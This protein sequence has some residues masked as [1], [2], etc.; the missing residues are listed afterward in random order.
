MQIRVLN[1]GF[2]SIKRFIE[3]A[4][5]FIYPKVCIVS[6]NKIPDFNSNIYVDDAVLY[7]LDRVTPENN[8]E[9]RDRLR[10]DFAYCTY[11]FREKSGVQTIIHHLKYS[12]F[13]NIGIML[14]NIAGQELVSLHKNEIKKYDYLIPVPLYKSRIRERGYNQSKIISRGISDVTGI[15]VLSKNILRVRN[16]KSQTGLN[17]AE[18]KENVKGAFDINVN[19][20]NELTAKNVLIVDDVITTGATISEVIR[21]IKNAGAA[22]IGVVSAGLTD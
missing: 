16:T 13:S 3:I 12:G 4:F 17:I 14:G 11:Y 6:G 15:P 5:D 2:Q 10:C 8:N 18:R 9:L 19:F 21:V 1:T 20:I 7:S 22:R